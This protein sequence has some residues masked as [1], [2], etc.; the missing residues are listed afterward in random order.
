MGLTL[1][2]LRFKG[3]MNTKKGDICRLLIVLVILNIYSFYL[4]SSGRSE[5]LLYT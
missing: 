4:N 2:F 5:H 1:F 3:V